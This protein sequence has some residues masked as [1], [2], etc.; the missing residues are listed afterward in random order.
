MHSV[1]DFRWV[2]C[3]MLDTSKLGMERGG[4]ALQPGLLQGWLAGPHTQWDGEESRLDVVAHCEK[5]H[6][7]QGGVWLPWATLAI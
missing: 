6:L 4:V 5:G 2:P 3:Y 7:M 1:S